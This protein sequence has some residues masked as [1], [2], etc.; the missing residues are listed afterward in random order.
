MKKRNGIT[1]VELLLSLALIS[2]IVASGTNLLIFTTKSH[3]KAMD[4][5]NVQ[6]NVRLISQSVNNAIRDSSGVFL[7]AKD[8]PNDTVNISEYFTEGWNYLMLNKDGTRLVEWVWNGKKHIERVIIDS[9]PNVKYDLTY[10]K[11]SVAYLDKLLKYTL[12]INVNGKNRT[13]ESELEGINTLQIIDRSYGRTANT[14]AY[15]SDPRLTNIGVAQ[16]AVSFVIDKSGSMS[17]KDMITGKDGRGNYIKDSR[18]NVLKNEATKMIEA[19]AEY[20]NIYL[21]ISPFSSTANNS[22]GDNLNKM[23]SLKSNKDAFI[24]KNNSIIKN[25]YA[26]GG[27]NTGDGM[28][29]GLSSIVNFNNETKNQDK[30]TK[31]FMIILVDGD[32]T[33]ATATERINNLYTESGRSSTDYKPQ[34]VLNKGTDNERAYIYEGTTIT[35]WIFKNYTHR[36]RYNGN[37]EITYCTTLDNNVGD[38]SNSGSKP[39][40]GLGENDYRPNGKVIGDGANLDDRG[41]A[42]VSIIGQKINEYKNTREDGI[43]VFVIGFSNDP[44]LVGLQQIANATKSKHGTHGTNYKYYKAD[45]AEAL[46]TVLDE[47]KFQ[48][49][50]ALWH[51]GGP[52]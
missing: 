42:Y 7:L 49:S 40:Y 20:E 39:F 5:Y 33:F 27:T 46:E 22:S 4:E 11:E 43:E 28:R 48:I 10:D 44:S 50:E 37:N 2:I 15:R 3:S 41:K 1:L 36:Y 30:T 26:D 38:S 45:T 31:N 16:A 32:T 29:R 14:L 52:N 9:F 25:L 17:T 21:S 47:I 18:I 35:G 24:V 51:I 13:I 8:Y 34:V 6:S 19:L 12:D 23:L